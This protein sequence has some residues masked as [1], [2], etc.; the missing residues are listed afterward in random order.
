MRAMDP[1]RVA[2]LRLAREVDARVGRAH[3]RLREPQLASDDVRAFDERD[4]LVVGDAPAQPLAAEPTVGRDD[5]P[6]G[7]DVLECLPDKPR[8]VLGWLDDG[9]AVA[10]HAD[11]D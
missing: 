8:H 5:Q 3:A 1:P 4:T 7:R 11:P 2:T 9:V 10:D 6:L